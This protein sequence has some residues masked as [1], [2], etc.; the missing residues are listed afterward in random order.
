MG[1]ALLPEDVGGLVAGAELAPG[2]ARTLQ[3]AWVWGCELSTCQQ[4]LRTLPSASLEPR[5]LVAMRD[6]PPAE[7]I[8]TPSPLSQSG[9]SSI[10][11]FLFIFKL[12]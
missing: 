9:F 4:H 10:T 2:R 3:G 11:V 7:V 8:R 12:Q 5:T 1:S 6:L